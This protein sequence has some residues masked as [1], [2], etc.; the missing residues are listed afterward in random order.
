[1]F[2]RPQ[3]LEQYESVLRQVNELSEHLSD[4]LSSSRSTNHRNPFAHTFIH[5][6]RPPLSHPPP[7]ITPDQPPLAPEYNPHKTLLKT[8]AHPEYEEQKT[9]LLNSFG[10]DAERTAFRPA[11]GRKEWWSYTADEIDLLEGDDQEALYNG[12]REVLRGRK[13]KLRQAKTVLGDL[14][15]GFDWGMRLGEE[16]V[17]EVE[18]EEEDEEM[19]EYT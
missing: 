9:E 13:R 8:Y 15:E 19:E 6:S 14:K 18:E 16:E 3:I 5:A 1:M 10:K 11:T 2:S 12:L 7:P 4:P 17:E